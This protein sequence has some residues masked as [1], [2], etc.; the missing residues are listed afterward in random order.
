MTKILMNRRR[1]L[2]GTAL[3]AAALASPVY[4]RR[5]MAQSGG[6]VNSGPTTVS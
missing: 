1:F 5:R 2:H 6:E 4:L 3:G